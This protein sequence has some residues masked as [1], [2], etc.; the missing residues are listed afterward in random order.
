MKQHKHTSQGN[1]YEES[2][3]VLQRSMRVVL[4]LVADHQKYLVCLESCVI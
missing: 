1:G 3:P 4:S 2:D